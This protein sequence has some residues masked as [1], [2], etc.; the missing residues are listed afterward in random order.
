MKTIIAQDL[1]ARREQ[2]EEISGTELYELFHELSGDS[3]PRGHTVIDRDSI[4]EVAAS[5]RWEHPRSYR[6][7]V[8][9]LT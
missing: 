4:E 5:L 8:S 9:F 1:Y 7:L 2:T 6:F 3:T